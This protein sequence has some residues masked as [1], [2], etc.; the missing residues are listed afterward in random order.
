MTACTG[1][2]QGW[3]EEG[4]KGRNGGESTNSSYK[5]MPTS[6]NVKSGDSLF[7]ATPPPPRISTTNPPTT[8]LP[9]PD[10]R[11]NTI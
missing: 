3:Q 9:D 7:C 2:Q 10:L 5:E 4:E 11:I 6:G 8:P 1:D